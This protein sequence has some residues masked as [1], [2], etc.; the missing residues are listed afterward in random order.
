MATVNVISCCEWV[1]RFAVPEDVTEASVKSLLFY[2]LDE[3]ARALEEPPRYSWIDY[4]IQ[5]IIAYHKAQYQ[6]DPRTANR[7]ER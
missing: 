5:Q 6:N 3:S 4:P 7:S 2:L 1:D